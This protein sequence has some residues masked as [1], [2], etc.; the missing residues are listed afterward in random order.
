MS[1][2]SGG[3]PRS[4]GAAGRVR[5]VRR[6]TTIHSPGFRLAY[7]RSGPPQSTP[8]LVVPGGPGLAAIV[9]YRFLRRIAAKRGLDLIMVEHRG[10]GFSRKDHT[11]SVLPQSAMTITAV[12]DDIAAVLDHEGVSRVF[13]AGSSYGSYLASAFATRYPERVAGVLLD[14]ALQSANDLQV[15]RELVRE[16]FWEA[17]S[18]VSRAVQKLASTGNIADRVLLD[19]VRAAY[20]LGGD[21]LL[22]SMLELRQQ[23]PKSVAWR[24]L[25]SYAIRDEGMARLPYV[26][27]FDVAGTIGFRELRYGAAPDGAPLDPA[28]TYSEVRSKFP[29][30]I[31]EPYDLEK[32]VEDFHWPVVVLVGSRDIRTPPAIAA[33]V[34]ARAPQST[35]VCVEN[36][37]SALDTHPLA[38]LNAI[39]FL[40]LGVSEQLTAHQ[41]RLSGLPKRGISA[42]LPQLLRGLSRFELAVRTLSMLCATKL[43]RWVRRSEQ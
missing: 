28:L 27:E 14:S 32:A 5:R 31:G 42:R 39:S 6:E 30:F 13:I 40:S 15:E 19:T 35:T 21:P 12:L 36:G 25:E 18:A 43:H 29:D 22:L 2:A 26:F 33:R 11:G 34:A 4:I 23:H 10:V 20:E 9:P 37:H 16:V 8:I 38:F 7:V 24:A 41:T 3:R 17:D 1:L